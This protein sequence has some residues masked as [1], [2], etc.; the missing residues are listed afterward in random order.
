MTTFGRRVKTPETKDSTLLAEP[1]D[2]P[3]SADSLVTLVTSPEYSDRQPT[4]Q[5]EKINEPKSATVPL[6]DMAKLEGGEQ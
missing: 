6:L 3:P 1:V 2:D 4:V 5:P